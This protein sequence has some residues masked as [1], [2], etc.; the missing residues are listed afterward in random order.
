VLRIRVEVL[1]KS[2]LEQ[3]R[4]LGDLRGQRLGDLVSDRSPG[5]VA[6]AGTHDGDLAPD[7]IE[8]ELVGVHTV[9]VNPALDR[10]EAEESEGEG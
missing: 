2:A 10:D 1:A 6:E 4:V 9:D 3:G 5:M 7:G 8:I